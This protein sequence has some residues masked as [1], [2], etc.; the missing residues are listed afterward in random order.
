VY[1]KVFRSL[2]DGTLAEHWEAWAVLVFLLAHSDPD[3]FVDMTPGAIARRSGLPAEVVA[4]GLET[5]EAP[6]PM[7]RSSAEDGRRIVRLDPGRSWGWRLV[8]Y[9]SY[10]GIVDA[11]TQREQAR[12]RQQARRERAAGLVV[13]RGVTDRHAVSPQA[14]VEV[15]AE[16]EER[17][18]NTVSGAGSPDGS[19]GPGQNGLALGGEGRK[20]RSAS[21]GVRRAA[22]EVDAAALPVVA[23]PTNRPGSEWPVGQL[24]IDEWAAL[25]PAVDVPQTLRAMRGWLLANPTKRKTW[26]GTPAFVNRWLATE[27]DRGGGAPARGH[28]GGSDSRYREAN[29]AA[30]RAANKGQGNG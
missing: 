28:R 21:E 25:Y 13:S 17:N 10:R 15:E 7:S 4:R 26:R 27:Q 5:L 19:P 9:R 30:L 22:L 11:E 16:A 12:I 1:A 8:N 24:M 23:L 14:E 20:P 6:D 2:W 18:T 29:A 3:G